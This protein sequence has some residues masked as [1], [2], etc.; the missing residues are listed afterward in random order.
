MNTTHFFITK[1][2]N[3][4]ELQQIALNHLLDINTKYFVNI[5]EKC[6]GEP[7]SFFVNG[8]ILS[9]DNPLRFVKNLFGINVNHHECSSIV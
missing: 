6:N 7:Y 1:I 5:Y 2:L 8:T 9:S 3:K 4:R